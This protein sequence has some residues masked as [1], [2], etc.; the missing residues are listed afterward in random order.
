MEKILT[1]IYKTLAITVLPL[2][3]H[4]LVLFAEGAFLSEF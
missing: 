2:I 4:L 3:N 1:Y